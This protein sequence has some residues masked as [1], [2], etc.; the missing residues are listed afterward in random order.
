MFYTKYMALF[1]SST[2][3]VLSSRLAQYFTT[4]NYFLFCREKQTLD[5]F[6]KTNFRTIL[7]I[8]PAL[9]EK[10]YLISQKHFPN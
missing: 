4:V 5:T 10:I 8:S 7:T 3:L 1:M 9:K 6:L 2:V